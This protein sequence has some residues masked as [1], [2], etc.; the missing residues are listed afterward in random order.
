MK[1]LLGLVCFYY[2]RSFIVICV[3]YLNCSWKGCV[4]C[5]LSLWGCL[6]KTLCFCILFC[7]F[8][9]QWFY[10]SYLQLMLPT[11]YC[12]FTFFGP[13]LGRHTYILSHFLQVSVIWLLWWHYLAA[14]MS[15]SQCYHQGAIHDLFIH[16]PHSVIHSPLA[17]QWGIACR[18]PNP[19]WQIN[20]PISLPQCT[21][22]FWAVSKSFVQRASETKT[23]HLDI[24]W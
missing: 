14:S 9:F 11:F 7:L 2:F 4:I 22:I 8:C 15:L 18:P 13:W 16:I 3:T 17:C 12:L 10:F 6:L 5:K 19:Q 1:V 20:P 23:V 24:W 21:N